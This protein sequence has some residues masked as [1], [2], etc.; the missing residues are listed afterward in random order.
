MGVEGRTAMVETEGHMCVWA[1]EDMGM[2]TEVMEMEEE[3][4]TG[5]KA[6]N[7]GTEVEAEAVEAEAKA[8]TDKA[9]AGPWGTWPETE[10]G[11]DIVLVTRG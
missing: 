6:D 1:E 4:S 2:K 10:A 11:M 7:A 9:E 3:G 5:A 8:G